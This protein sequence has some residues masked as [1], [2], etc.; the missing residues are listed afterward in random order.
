MKSSIEHDLL[1]EDPSAIQ[2]Q[3]QILDNLLALPCWR[4]R[5]GGRPQVIAEQI[6]SSFLSLELNDSGYRRQGWTT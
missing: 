3:E 6:A 2:K 1:A 5:Y 4:L